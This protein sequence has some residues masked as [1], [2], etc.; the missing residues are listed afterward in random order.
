MTVRSCRAITGR[1]CYVANHAPVAARHFHIILNYKA[2]IVVG[3]VLRLEK[4]SAMA[5]CGNVR[6]GPDVDIAA[7][8]AKG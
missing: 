7:A 3:D 2:S 5:E 8:Q 1:P 6:F 4:Q